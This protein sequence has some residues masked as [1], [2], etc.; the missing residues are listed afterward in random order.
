MQSCLGREKKK[1]LSNLLN[2]HISDTKWQHNVALIKWL[3][4]SFPSQFIF[5]K[6][7]NT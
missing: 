1:D 6:N 4:Y 2:Q 3:I 5:K 7:I